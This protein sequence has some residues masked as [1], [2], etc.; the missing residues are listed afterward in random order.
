MKSLVTKR[1]ATQSDR[2]FVRKVHH[3]AYRDVVVRQFGSW[4]EKMQD[5]FFDKSWE[6]QT[7]EIIISS[8]LPAGYCSIE[9][10]AKSIFI[11][12]LVLLPAFQGKGIGSKIL[13][14]LME[15][16]KVKNV[17][18]QLNVLK[19]NQAQHL[20][21]KL[22]FKNTGLTNTHFKMEFSSAK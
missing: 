9:R 12:D 14:D 13:V 16:A 5:D 21:Q 1:A 10:P 18:I 3:A 15:E 6:S 8:G 7:H 17:P 19:E 11:N 22:G 2:E 4:D 20:Y